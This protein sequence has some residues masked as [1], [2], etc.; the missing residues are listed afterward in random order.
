MEIHPINGSVTNLMTA[1]KQGD[2]SPKDD[3]AKDPKIQLM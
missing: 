2:A 1:E 3:H